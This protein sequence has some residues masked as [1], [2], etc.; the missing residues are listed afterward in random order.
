MTVHWINTKHDFKKYV[1]LRK[2]H[3]TKITYKILN[4][5]E[6]KEKE[7]TRMSENFRVIVVGQQK[8]NPRALRVL[9]NRT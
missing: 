8:M 6:S 7:D 3:T 1:N 2:V 4:K 9:I 5:N